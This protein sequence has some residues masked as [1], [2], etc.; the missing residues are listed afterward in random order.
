MKQYNRNCP[1]CD[2][3]L[4]YKSRHSYYEC[5]KKNSTCIECY[6]IRQKENH[7]RYWAGK[8]RSAETIE[9]ISKTKQKNPSRP[10]LGKTHNAETR[11]KLSI[12][13]LLNPNRYWLGKKRPEVAG[14]KNPTW[15]GGYQRKLWRNSKRRVLKINAEGSH[16]LEE[17]LNMKIQYGFTCPCCMKK[18]PDII[19]SRD[20]IVPLAKGGSDDISNI[21]PLCR[22]CNPSKGIKIIKFANPHQFV[23]T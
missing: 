11:L 23:I 8:K 19:L 22:S 10:M 9:K 6:R 2:K 5:K 1:K 21:Q 13:N 12:A 3:V 7:P 16:S 14:E 18:E 15:K 4:H 17:W 20:H